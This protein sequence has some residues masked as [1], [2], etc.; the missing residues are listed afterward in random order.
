MGRKVLVYFESNAWRWCV[1]YSTGRVAR[2]SNGGFDDRDD[3]VA[4][5]Y[6]ENPWLPVEVDIFSSAA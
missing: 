3:A 4:S 2:Y 5:A 1:L 6:L